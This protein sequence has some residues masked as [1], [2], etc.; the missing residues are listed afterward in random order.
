MAEIEVEL[1]VLSQ[2]MRTMAVI[3]IADSDRGVRLRNAGSRLPTLTA[4]VRLRAPRYGATAFAWLTK[5]A[6][7]MASAKRWPS[8][9]SPSIARSEG[10]RRERDSNPWYGYPYTRF[11]SVLLQPLGHL[12]VRMDLIV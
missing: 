9:S 11:P 2:E 6:V 5:L 4:G 7:E 3:C 12:S 1:P 8:R 10:W